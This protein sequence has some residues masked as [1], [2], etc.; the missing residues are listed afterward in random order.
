[1]DPRALLADVAAA[2]QGVRSL[3][4]EALS[5]TESGDANE[6]SSNHYK[7]QFLYRAPNHFRSE[8]LGTQENLLV[9]DG[10]RLHQTF[11]AFPGHTPRYTANPLPE[12]PKR[13]HVFH[14]D[15]PFGNEPF[16]F[17]SIAEHVAH[18]EL[19]RDEDGCHVVSVAYDPTPYHGVESRGPVL[20][21]IR[22]ADHIVVRQQGEIGHRHP[23]S[24]DVRWQRHDVT[25]QQIEVN[26]AIDDATFL[27]T[28]PAGVEEMPAGRCGVSV[29][30]GGGFM[31]S[32]RGS[33]RRY[34]H[35]GSHEFDGDT[36]VDRS[37]WRMR[38]VDLNF[39]R[40]FTF[41][42]D[43]SELRVVERVRGPH[44]EKEITATIR[45]RSAADDAR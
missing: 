9:S 31:R 38:G 44:E 23:A 26:G 3:R 45:L 24:D 41:S 10:D 1:M 32:E 5:Q 15:M 33:G 39:E 21:W 27:F 18:A 25:F 35:W 12:F 36:L 11:G 28:P 30:G 8:R 29:S 13:P 14:W 4:I 16:L 20:F 42:P 7:V 40:R 43:E 22:I 6:G 19:L 2:Y 17:H 34:E 37:R